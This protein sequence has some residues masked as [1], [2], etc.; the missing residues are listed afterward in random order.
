MHT[1]ITRTA[2][3]TAMALTKGTYQA[4]LIDG[5]NS[6]AGSDLVGTARRYGGRYARSRV[7][8]IAACQK[9]GLRLVLSPIGAHRRLIAV[10]AT[11]TEAR[12][13]RRTPA[14]RANE[15]EARQLRRRI[16]IIAARAAAEARRRDVLDDAAL[17]TVG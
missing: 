9:A 10:I 7:S 12:R 17:A 11:E 15:V 16:E 6:W 14:G 1:I 5:M 4:G 2:Y 8:L 3:A 13:I